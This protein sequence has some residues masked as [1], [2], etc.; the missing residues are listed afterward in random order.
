MDIKIGQIWELN[1]HTDISTM[2]YGSYMIVL[3]KEKEFWQVAMFT[4]WDESCGWYGAGVH[5]FT[6]DEISRNAEMKDFLDSIV[7]PKDMKL[8]ART[9]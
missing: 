4:G 3:S 6:E 1:R 2:D 7:K 5:N 8:T 9:F